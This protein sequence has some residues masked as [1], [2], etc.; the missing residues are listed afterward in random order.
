[1]TMV[2]RDSI[3]QQQIDGAKKVTGGS[4]E[5]ARVNGDEVVQAHT[6]VGPVRSKK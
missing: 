4:I 5:G 1:M 6:P 2:K 3:S